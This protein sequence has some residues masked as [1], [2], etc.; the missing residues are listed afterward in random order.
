MLNR[1]WWI[2][3]LSLLICLQGM[4]GGIVSLLPS[5]TD[6][7]VDLG[8]A[9]S[10]TGITRYGVV[11]EG[12]S[13]ERLGGMYDLN[14][15]AVLRLKP[16]LVL[17]YHGAETRLKPVSDAGIP[18]EYLK[19][20]TLDEVIASYLRVGQLLGK[21]ELA[22]KRVAQLE[23]LLQPAETPVEKVPSMLVITSEGGMN[24]SRIF[25]SANSFYGNLLH[26]LGARNAV[27]SQVA[28]PSLS[29]EGLLDT[30]PDIIILLSEK[31]EQ[32]TNCGEKPFSFLKACRNKAIFN[33]VD[34]KMMH[35][36]PIVFQLVPILKRILKAYADHSTALLP[37][38]IEIH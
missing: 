22:T 4:A 37:E 23:S 1:V 5:V 35:P 36:G 24:A 12:V 34:P 30:N 25:V 8:S 28:Y 33:V 31:K 15:E 29:L 19:I 2:A 27:D 18:V 20:N 3:C 7:V 6:M 17:A 21:A 32:I 14:V 16:D 13:A 26:R 10:L 38:H 11:P 9:N